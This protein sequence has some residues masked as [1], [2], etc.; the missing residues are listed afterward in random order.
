[1]SL[2]RELHRIAH[3]V[4]HDLTD[5]A[6]IA[7]QHRRQFGIHPHNQFKILLGNLG[8]HKCRHVLNRLAQRE[9]CRVQFHLT[10]IQLGEIQ[11]VIDD[12]QQRRTGLHNN[13]GE[14][15]LLGI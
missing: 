7:H 12:R 14:H 4:G 11:N 5:P 9:R 3:Q 6:H 13:I 10:R 8:R 2:L 1:M 15:L